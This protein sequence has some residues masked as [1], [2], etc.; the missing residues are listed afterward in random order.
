LPDLFD[1]VPHAGQHRILGV[2]VGIADQI[3]QCI[4]LRQGAHAQRAVRAGFEVD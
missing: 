2:P 1:E 3:G 4:A